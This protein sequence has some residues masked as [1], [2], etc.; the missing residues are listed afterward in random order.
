MRRGCVCPIKPARPRLS[1][2]Q[3]L[4]SCVVLPLPVSPHTIT[5][6]LC[7]I[8]SEISSRREE[9]GSS[10]GYSGLGKLAKRTAYLAC[11][12][13]IFCAISFIK[14]CAFCADFSSFCLNKSSTSR[15]LRRKPYLSTSMQVC[16]AV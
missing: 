1:C 5:T 7:L 9:T 3:I 15:A 13:L 8:A 4:G 2:K 16:S 11:E 12:M 14:R 6:W 10:K